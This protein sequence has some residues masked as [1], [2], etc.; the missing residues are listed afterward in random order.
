MDPDGSKSNGGDLLL[1][2][3]FTTIT[4]TMHTMIHK[5]LTPLALFAIVI[6]LI[7]IFVPIALLF[8][9]QQDV[10]LTASPAEALVGIDGMIIGRGQACVPKV[11]RGEHT[12]FVRKKQH[13]LSAKFSVSDNMVINTQS[14][15]SG[16]D[17]SIS[18]EQ[19]QLRVEPISCTTWSFGENAY[20]P[21][22]EYT[23]MTWPYGAVLIH[24]RTATNADEAGVAPGDYIVSTDGN[25]RMFFPNR[26]D[27]EFLTPQR[28]LVAGTL[29]DASTEELYSIT[30]EKITTLQVAEDIP[31]TELSLSLSQQYL[32]Y[33]SGSRRCVSTFNNKTLGPCVD[34]K[35]QVQS[36]LAN[37]SDYYLEYEWMAGD[38]LFV[39]RVRSNSKSHED[40]APGSDQPPL[41]I[42][43]EIARFVFDPANKTLSSQPL[44]DSITLKKQD[45]FLTEQDQPLIDLFNDG[46]DYSLKYNYNEGTIEIVQRSTD[47]KEML[48][49]APFFGE[50]TG[51]DL[52][53]Y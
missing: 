10:L 1:L 29:A 4:F 22:Y 28:M 36:Q 8:T 45:A 52:Y 18:D 25:V 11:S 47:S 13:K 2:P 15:N 42:Q 38:D 33:A 31:R 50:M 19:V 43:D 17:Q 9:E 37:E 16:E 32:A 6:F 44:T 5:M 7:I 30:S 39:I 40:P 20:L 27:I 21:L 24:M 46:N 49:Y 14:N 41:R 48:M 35:P 51:F 53:Y 12:F 23:D 34:I 26:A 3:F